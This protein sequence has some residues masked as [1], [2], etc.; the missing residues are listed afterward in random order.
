MPVRIPFAG[1]LCYDVIEGKF[2][3]HSVSITYPGTTCEAYLN[4]TYDPIDGGDR[5]RRLRASM[6]R[7]S[8]D[9][10]ISHYLFKG[11]KAEC[12]AWLEKPGNQEVLKKDYAELLS[13]VERADD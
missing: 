7:Q 6:C 3:S 13:S 5:N 12:L 8:S 9:R 1:Q 2:D 4:Y 11:S 10:M